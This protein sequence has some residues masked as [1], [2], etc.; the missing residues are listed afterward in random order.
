MDAK[1]IIELAKARGIDLGEDAAELLAKGGAH[2]IV[3]IFGAIVKETKTGL[4]DM[5]FAA[6]EPQAREM[7]DEISVKF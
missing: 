4:D 2:L 3:D 7:A 6:I 5:A 1:K